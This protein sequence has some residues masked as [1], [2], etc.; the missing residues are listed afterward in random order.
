MGTADLTFT[1]LSTALLAW[2]IVKPRSMTAGFA[3]LLTICAVLT[4]YLMTE[5][6]RIHMREG[7]GII[8]A[9]GYLLPCHTKEC[10]YSYPEIRHGYRC[11][12]QLDRYCDD[13]TLVEYAPALRGT[14]NSKAPLSE[15]SIRSAGRR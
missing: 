9:G 8:G 5:R 4:L 14:T 3:I 11:G 1:L 12:P 10:S 7:P 6:E 13:G 2:L 15:P